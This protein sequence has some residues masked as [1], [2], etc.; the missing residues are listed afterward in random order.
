MER[1]PSYVAITPWSDAGPA[2]IGLCLIFPSGTPVRGNQG[3]CVPTADTEVIMESAP[4]S[5]V[6]YIKTAKSIMMYA[7]IGHTGN[8]IQLPNVGEPI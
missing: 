5:I 8:N 3:R 4:I 6:Y 2:S 7:K 1:L